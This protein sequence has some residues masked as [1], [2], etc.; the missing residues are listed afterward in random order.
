MKKI[1][2]LVAERSWHEYRNFWG[3]FRWEV[4]YFA[5]TMSSSNFLFLIIDL[6]EM[7]I[8]YEKMKKIYFLIA[9]L[10]CSI[11]MHISVGIN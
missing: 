9:W 10:K 3:L 4:R 5:P 8:Y 2:D 7:I 6:D 1:R 11:L